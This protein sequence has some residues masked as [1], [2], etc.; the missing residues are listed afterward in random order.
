M[1][2]CPI[3]GISTKKDFCEDHKPININYKDVI[4]RVCDCKKYFHRNKWLPFSSLKS[5]AKKIAEDAIK[6]NVKINPLL[7]EEIVKKRFEIE[8]NK[9]GEMF[10]IPGKV[11]IEKCPECSKIGTEY[12]EAIFQVRPRDEKLLEFVE[13]QVKTTPGAFISK[14]EELKDGWD[15]Y[16]SSNKAA[17]QIGSKCKKSFKGEL[18]ISRKLFGRDKLRSRDLYRVT[19][20]F[21]KS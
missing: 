11:Q 2:F 4:V 18:K 16:L 17:T 5:I 15:L 13:Q 14:K 6:D 8:V 20:L 21:R 19:V 9:L 1:G 12:F 7:D 10:I 3:C